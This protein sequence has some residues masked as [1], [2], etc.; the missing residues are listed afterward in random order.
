MV[1]KDKVDIAVQAYLSTAST[2]W[3]LGNKVLYDLCK[4][5]PEHIDADEIV[6]KIWLIGRSYAAA[7]ERRKNKQ[8][9]TGDFYYEKVAPTILSI[10]GELDLKL[11]MLKKYQCPT[12]ES[13]GAVLDLHGCLTKTFEVLTAMNKRSLASKYLH[14]H[15]PEMFFIYD[16]RANKAMR[17]F[18]EKG[19]ENLNNYIS[20]DRDMEYT[21]FCARA[22]ELKDY[23]YF[24][25]ERKLTP[26]ELDELLLY[27]NGS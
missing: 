26:R 2:R 17:K 1:C 25:Y 13:L 12:N 3:K 16:S 10:G 9:F 21:D 24:E 5:H 20:A 14:F 18:V 8:S 27:N 15:C 7:I 19:K 11:Q 22:M 4:E 6:A 23:I